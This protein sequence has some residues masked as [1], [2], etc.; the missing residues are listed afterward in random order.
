MK[1]NIATFAFAIAFVILFSWST[2]SESNDLDIYSKLQNYVFESLPQE[3]YNLYKNDVISLNFSNSVISQ[4]GPDFITS[5]LIENLYLSNNHIET[6]AHDAF[7]KLPNLTNLFLSNNMINTPNNLFSFGN[8]EKLKIIIMNN[9]TSN[10]QKY[11]STYIQEY[12]NLEILSLRNN[13]INQLKYL[14]QDLQCGSYSTY[15]LQTLPLPK[16][17][18]L[19]LSQN[20]LKNSEFVQILPNTLVY[21]DLDGNK[22]KS[23]K[24][25]K[26]GQNLVTLN[27]NNNQLHSVSLN[28]QIFPHY[29]VSCVELDNLKNLRYLSIAKNQIRNIYSDAFRDTDKLI[30]LN[31]SRNEI[32]SEN[33]NSETFATL[34]RLHTLDL[35][36]N[37]LDNVPEV[38]NEIQISILSL[39]HNK[40]EKIDSN[41]FVQMPKLTTLSLKE[42]H[43]NW[44]DNKAFTDLSILEELDLSENKL[45]YLPE[46]WCESLISL[47]Y[48]DLSGNTITSL[49]SLSLTNTIPLTEL[50]LAM[51]QLEY[52]NIR[53][54]E[55]LPQNLTVHLVQD[56]NFTRRLMQT[57]FTYYF[58]WLRTVL[59]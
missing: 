58:S 4:I 30:Y 28:C 1:F 27:L 51:N 26:K 20:L 17:K 19:D 13:N 57:E 29:Y 10:Y 21:L 24:L 3:Q 44:I 5:P 39:R 43:I 32:E 22:L 7:R 59:I 2:Q 54:F 15:C 47:K 42:N 25:Y 55:D 6:I 16:L 56:S 12:P 8:H 14:M 11:Q 18:I 9:A 46:R 40:I 33:L 31:L 41:A 34:Q 36:F 38:L 52:L 50:N 35:S 37:Q 45:H 53:Y 49:E 48:L 23:F